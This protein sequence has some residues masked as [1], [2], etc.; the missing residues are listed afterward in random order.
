MT[1]SGTNEISDSE[2]IKRV[3]SG[4]TDAFAG[5]VRKYQAPIRRFC[6][7]V[8]GDGALADDAAQEAFLKAYLALKTFRGDSTFGTWLYRIAA[9]QCRD[10]LR[11]QG[12]RR[13][14]SLEAMSEETSGDNPVLV[15][16]RSNE[17]PASDHADATLQLLKRLPEKSRE[18]LVLREVQGLSYEEISCALG[19]SLDAV[20]AR[21]RRARQEAVQHAKRLIEGVDVTGEKRK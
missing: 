12:R 8:L 4:D 17:A 9:N 20:K 6:I 18:V 21:L 3:L 11:R 2:I 15:D 5:L 19:C 1:E 10:L 13:L 16:P 14:V 7:G